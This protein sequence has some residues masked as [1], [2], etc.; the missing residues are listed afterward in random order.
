MKLDE[1]WVYQPY[2]QPSVPMNREKREKKQKVER[3]S[4]RTRTQVWEELGGSTQG[5][6]GAGYGPAGLHFVQIS[7]Q[8]EAA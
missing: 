5:V 1:N 3:G 7:R 2:S 8:L 4:V 6:Q